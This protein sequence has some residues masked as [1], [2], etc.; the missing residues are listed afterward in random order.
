MTHP[1][2]D[3]DT[4]T[5]TT[6][7]TTT[8]NPKSDSQPKLDC[9]DSLSTT[10]NK[11]NKLPMAVDSVEHVKP[12]QCGTNTT[13]TAT[14]G[15]STSNDKTSII[16]NDKTTT[17]TVPAAS[18]P[19]SRISMSYAK[20]K[21]DRRKSSK[22]KNRKHLDRKNR[23]LLA[24]VEDTPLPAEQGSWLLRLFESKL[25]DM[26]IAISY[27]F[28]SKESGVLAYLGNKLFVSIGKF[29]FSLIYKLSYF[30][31]TLMPFIKVIPYPTIQQS[32]CLDPLL[33]LI[34]CV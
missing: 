31:I 5:T 18:K 23:Q 21:R 30:F 7:T 28:N 4:H 20:L 10:I 13:P 27:M 17:T 12:C 11:S 1:N 19:S 9:S 25:F 22:S 24:K 16:T 26:P 34:C 14:T 8:T 6:T 29:L 2:H 15:L 33:L 3:N 32:L